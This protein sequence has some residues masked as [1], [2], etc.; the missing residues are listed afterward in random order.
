MI[1]GDTV[2]FRWGYIEQQA[3]DEVKSLVQRARD[4]RQVPLDYSKNAAPIWMVTDGCA[5]GI[6]GLVSQGTD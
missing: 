1:T 3:F 2:P 4:H 5:T 6:S